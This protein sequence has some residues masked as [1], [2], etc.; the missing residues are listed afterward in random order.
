MATDDGHLLNMEVDNRQHIRSL[1]PAAFVAYVQPK[2]VALMANGT[3]LTAAM[4]KFNSMCRPDDRSTWRK[5]IVV[6]IEDD[7]VYLDDYCGS[8]TDEQIAGLHVDR[9]DRIT[10]KRGEKIRNATGR[11]LARNNA[12]YLSAVVIHH[13]GTPPGMSFGSLLASPFST[14]DITRWPYTDS[15]YKRRLSLLARGIS[16]KLP[17]VV[18][19]A[20]LDAILSDPYASRYFFHSTRESYKPIF[21]VAANGAALV[22]TSSSSPPKTP[23]SDDQSKATHAWLQPDLKESWDMP[24]PPSRW[25][26]GDRNYRNWLSRMTEGTEDTPARIA[27]NEPPGVRRIVFT[28]TA[29]IIDGIKAI[30]ADD[31]VVLDE[32]RGTDQ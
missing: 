1:S 3:R 24:V 23:T 25:P 30:S 10:F 29:G 21:P 17:Q 26:H 22:S 20:S 28:S 9:I 6:R 2:L 13:G 18:R 5:D 8:P 16:L 15:S 14:P 19:D 12:F 32:K 31:E 27:R 4:D 11:V 7:E